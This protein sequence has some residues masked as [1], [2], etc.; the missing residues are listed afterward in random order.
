LVPTSDGSD[1]PIE[2][3]RPDEGLGVIVGF[4]EQAVDGGVGIADQAE[5]AALATPG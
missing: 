3:G 1:D 2:V 5:G 4:L